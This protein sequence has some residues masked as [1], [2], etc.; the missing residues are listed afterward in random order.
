[1][2]TPQITDP[3]APV[4]RRMDFAFD[5]AVPR[6]WFADNP[7]ATHVANG[8]HLV[9]PEGER[10]FIRS[11]KHY[12]DEVR[13][14]P[15][16]LARVKGFFAQEVHHGRE[17]EHSFEMLERQGYDVK[18]FLHLYE[19]VWLPRIER[20][21][22][23]ILNLAGTA[24]LEHLT[25]SLGEAA[26]TEDFLDSA[27]PT[28]RALLR[29]HAAEEIEHKSVAFDV[30]ERVGGGYFTRVL[31]MFLGL[32]GLMVFWTIAS[33]RLLAQE[34]LPKE[35]R[36]AYARAMRK[37]R[38]DNTRKVLVRAVLSYL[39]P[40]FHPDDRDNYHLAARYLTEVGRLAG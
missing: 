14:D 12:L 5:D 38:A 22:P 1:M 19:Q 34:S 29:W 6:W 15:D 18:G 3:G 32:L 2:S 26:L 17:H 11:V 8:L 4:P 20:I 25:A 9:F 39:R 7:V 33:R 24:A 40:S 37:E 30:F 28:F 16:L 36:R 13:D 23:P 27:H 10:F 21:A 35:E 31:G